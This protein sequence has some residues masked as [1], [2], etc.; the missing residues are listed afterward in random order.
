MTIGAEILVRVI[1]SSFTMTTLLPFHTSILERISDP[2]SNNLLILARG[3][4]LRRIICTLLKI[5]D[6]PTNL[7]LLLNASLEE[8][9]GIGEQLGLMGCR[10]PG[11]RIVGYEMGKKERGDLYKG[12]GLCSVTSRILVVDMLQSDIPVDLITGIVVLHAEKHVFSLSQ[13]FWLT[14]QSLQ[15]DCVIPRSLHRPLIPRT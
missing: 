1:I 14:N 9:Q 11:L 12:G 4:G 10:K 13:N 5:Y 15:G 6:A 8:E 3:L 2:K 7:V